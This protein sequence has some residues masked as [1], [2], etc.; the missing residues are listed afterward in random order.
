[1]KRILFYFFVLGATS[2][3]AQTRN[4]TDQ[5]LPKFPETT[6]QLYNTYLS[7]VSDI[8]AETIVGVVPRLPRY[9]KGSYSNNFKGPEVRV[10][11]PAPEDN[12]EV[13]KPGKYT[14]N[15]RVSGTDIQPKAIVTVKKAK[16]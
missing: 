8:Y 15:G 14:V 2:V 9:L 13:L 1:M 7:G 16:A 3:F 10:I 5:S 12:S 6:P 4:A 11:W